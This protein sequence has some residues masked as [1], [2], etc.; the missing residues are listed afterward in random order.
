[1]LTLQPLAVNRPVSIETVNRALAAR[2]GPIPKLIA[3]TGG[4]NVPQLAA[5][6]DAELREHLVKVVLH[7]PGADEELAPDLRVGSAVDGQPGDLGLLGRKCVVGAAG[8]LANGLA[9]GQELAP[10]ALRFF[11]PGRAGLSWPEPLRTV[12]RVLS[13]FH[14]V[15]NYGLFAVMTTS[16]PEIAIEGSNDGVEWKEYAFRWKPG[17]PERRPAFVEPHQPRLDWQMWFAAL[18][19]YRNEPWFL[20][21]CEQLLRGPP[22][23]WALLAEDRPARPPRYLRALVYDYRFTDAATRRAT[24]AW[25]RRTLHGL[26]CPVLTLVDGRL[27]PALF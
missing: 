19:D 3:E 7:G 4:Q 20:A 23:V 26:Y 21:F 15:N 1:M 27:A 13:P 8:A 17:D 10:G 16:R 18:G 24:G 14:L 12:R 25:W 9:G 5:R 11:D 22:P 2:D 6:A